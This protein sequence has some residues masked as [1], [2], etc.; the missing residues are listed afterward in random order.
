MAQYV[1]LHEYVGQIISVIAADASTSD[2]IAASDNDNGVGIQGYN[3]VLFIL[4][5]GD[6]VTGATATVQ[7]QYSS[8]G[9][10][11]DAATSNTG[12]SCT[13]AVFTAVDSDGDNETYLLDFDV[14]A[15]GLSDAAGKLYA[16]L[17]AGDDTSK[18]ELALIAI[19]YN[20]TV[21]LPVSQENT[22]VEATG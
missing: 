14:V 1:K 4:S 17:A 16:T 2:G 21:S 7:I 5:V 19:P 20:G 10:A 22:V 6:I 9:S 18:V 8:T 13:D 15:H 11:S 3:N 12:M